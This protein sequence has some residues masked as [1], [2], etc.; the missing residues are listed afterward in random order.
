MRSDRIWICQG[1]LHSVC[2]EW[3]TGHLRMRVDQSC[4]SFFAFCFGCIDIFRRSCHVSL[5][6]GGFIPGFSFDDTVF[7][8]VGWVPTKPSM[9]TKFTY[10]CRQIYPYNRIKLG[11]GNIPYWWLVGTVRMYVFELFF[12]LLFVLILLRYWPWG[13]FR[14]FCY[15]RHFVVL[16]YHVQHILTTCTIFVED[17]T[18]LATLG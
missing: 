8:K 1:L 12:A 13:S 3:M 16:E 15:L 11:I 10:I 18:G 6:R 5:S 7:G 9:Y 2:M 14:Y 4:L 17:I